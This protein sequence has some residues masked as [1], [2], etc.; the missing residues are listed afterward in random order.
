MLLKS[1]HYWKVICEEKSQPR[2]SM[3]KGGGKEKTPKKKIRNKGRGKQ[4]V[5][6]REEKVCVGR[7]QICQSCLLIGWRCTENR[8]QTQPAVTFQITRRRVY[9][10]PHT[11]TRGGRYVAFYALNSK[12]CHLGSFFF[13]FLPDSITTTKTHTHPPKILGP[14]ALHI[15]I[16]GAFNSNSEI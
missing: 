15:D 9:S 10:P 5:G 7:G 2:Q 1:S 8:R 13:F 4:W 3:V 11:H 16:P 14:L 6:R 12:K